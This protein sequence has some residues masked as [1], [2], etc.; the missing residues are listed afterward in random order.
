MKT[1]FGFLTSFFKNCQ[2]FFESEFMGIH[3]KIGRN[4]KIE[5]ESRLH[6][7]DIYD[8]DCICIFEW[9]NLLIEMWIRKTTLK[10]YYLMLH[11]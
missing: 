5:I 1:T 2:L 10:K 8:D 4:Q 6:C 3:K 9:F 7:I 11:K